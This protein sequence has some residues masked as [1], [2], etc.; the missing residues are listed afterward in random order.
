MTRSFQSFL[1]ISGFALAC[2]IALGQG[3]SSPDKKELVQQKVAAVKEPI[4]QNQASLRQYTWTANTE[5]S[6]KGM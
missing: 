6:V 1:T 2:G 3:D 4:A 5:I